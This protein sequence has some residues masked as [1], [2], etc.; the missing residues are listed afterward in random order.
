ML[1][2][3]LFLPL[4]AL[5]LL[6]LPVLI[7]SSYSAGSLYDLV[8]SLWPSPS[9]SASVD[10]FLVTKNGERAKNQNPK[11]FALTGTIPVT[12]PGSAATFTRAK[13]EAQYALGITCETAVGEVRARISGKNGWTDMHNN[14][15]R[16]AKASTP[17]NWCL[18]FFPKATVHCAMLVGVA[19]A[20]RTPTSTIARIIATCACCCA[21]RR[22]DVRWR[23]P[24]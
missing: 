21:G 17:I 6:S 4:A 18:S 10:K 13:C 16:G 22:K 19:R 9:S 2:R 7:K 24:T 5:V 23:K 8:S 14:G 12:C 15:A 20:R 1:G 3:L 11:S